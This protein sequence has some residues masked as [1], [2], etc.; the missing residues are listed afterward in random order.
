[1]LFNARSLSNKFSDFEAVLNTTHT[2]SDVI[3]V[4]ET[5]FSAAKPASACQ[6]SSFK[7]FHNDREE[8]Q[9]GGVALYIRDDINC[10]EVFRNVTPPHLEALWVRLK[11]SRTV[12]LANDIYVGVIYSPP[13]SPSRGEMSDYIIAA[14]DNIRLQSDSATIVIMGD[15]NDLATDDIEHQTLL[16]QVVTEPTRG[17]ATLDKILTDMADVY[18]DPV[19]SAPIS[20]SDHCVITYRP[21]SEVPPRKSFN[22]SFRPFRDSSV[23]AFGQWITLMDWSTRGESDANALAA[24]LQELLNIKV[25]FLADWILYDIKDKIDPK[26]FGNRRGTSIVHCLVSLLDTIHTGI[27]TSGTF[28]NLCTIDF[29]KAFDHVNH[30]IVIQKLIGH[31]LRHV[32]SF[33][34]RCSSGLQ[35][36]QWNVISGPEHGDLTLTLGSC[37]VKLD[38][39]QEQECNVLQDRLRQEMDLLHAYQSKTRLQQEAQHHKEIK[40]LEERV[41]I[42]R[43]RLELKIEEDSAKLEGEKTDRKRKLFD[44]H[45]RETAEFNREMSSH[46]L[47]QLSIND[48]KQQVFGGSR[49]L[50]MIET[51]NN[52]SPRNVRRENSF[53]SSFT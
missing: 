51:S 17:T 20:S 52:S 24:D 6:L 32:N 18:N 21:L 50:S 2:N 46:G 9:G 49:P 8:R 42:R 33:L 48:I 38:K 30:A 29:S 35:F 4:T 10:Y 39:S 44:R 34:C 43:A 3:G 31:F 22:I 16:S 11:S 13:R 25:P 19:I 14:V 7:L 28:A 26:Q 45:K 40:E 12:Q 23:R 5:W 15:F 36:S 1:M 47:E 41:S 53:S 27:D 37:P